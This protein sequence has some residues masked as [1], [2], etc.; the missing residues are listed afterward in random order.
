MKLLKN[1]T[2]IFLVLSVAAV[3]LSGCMTRSVSGI[4]DTY[5]ISISTEVDEPVEDG[6]TIKTESLGQVH[7]G[8]PLL[9]AEISNM[10]SNVEDNYPFRD[11]SFESLG[12][13]RVINLS[14]MLFLQRDAAIG[15]RDA[16][17]GMKEEEI[18]SAL[19]SEDLLPG[20][21]V[22]L[23]VETHE[24]R[25]VFKLK[26][27]RLDQPDYVY[28]QTDLNNAKWNVDAYATTFEIHHL[29]DPG[30]SGAIEYSNIRS[31]FD[32]TGS[33]E[34]P[35]T[36]LYAG[37]S[38]FTIQ[39]SGYSS[40]L[41]SRFRII[42]EGKDLVGLSADAL[43]SMS[44]RHVWKDPNKTCPSVDEIQGMHGR[45]MLMTWKEPRNS[46]VF[47]SRVLFWSAP[48]GIQ[49]EMDE[50][51]RLEEIKRALRSLGLKGLGWSSIEYMEGGVSITGG[52]L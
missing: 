37:E 1:L 21:P 8:K 49:F 38:L 24:K 39:T 30:S 4:M 29:K 22:F 35:V 47:A 26:T 6:M 14:P 17:T 33:E 15:M 44:D 13:E 43:E 31:S 34:L 25:V 5:K 41:P 12:P 19:N 36:P 9:S 20:S 40:G 50:P 45:H 52:S 10:I 3:V 18:L 28:I 46:K 11:I 2:S 42:R 51:W 23:I 16:A 48:P 27:T 32:E 7:L